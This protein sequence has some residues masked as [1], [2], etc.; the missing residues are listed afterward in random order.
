M[1]TKLNYT[2]FDPAHLGD[3]IDLEQSNTV[4]SVGT[5]NTLNQYTRALYGKAKGSWRSELIV[6]GSA[7]IAGA[8]SVGLV[9]ASADTAS[10]VGGDANGYGYLLAEGE[11]HNDG[12]D[13]AT[14]SGLPVIAKGDV[15]GVELDAT[16]PDNPVATWKLNGQPIAS[17][18]IAPGTWYV[19]VSLAVPSGTDTLMAFINGGQRAFDYPALARGWYDIPPQLPTARVASADYIASANDALAHAVYDGCIEA[20]SFVI[21]RGIQFWVDGKAATRNQTGSLT[22]LNPDGIYDWLVDEDV[23]GLEVYLNITSQGEDFDSAAGVGRFTIKDAVAIDDGKIKLSLEDALA[24]LDVPLQR[25]L[26]HPDAEESAANKPW[27]III[28]AAR[29]VSPVLLDS[30][31]LIYALSD[32]AV[33]GLGYIRDKGDPWDPNAVPPD[34]TISADRRRMT[35]DSGSAP[36]GKVTADLSSV[37]GGT[38][39]TSA[40]DVFDQ[41]GHPFIA[42]SDNKPAGFEIIEFAGGDPSSVDMYQTN[43]V[44][45]KAGLLDAGLVY[46]TYIPGRYY[47]YRIKFSFLSHGD[48]DVF[49]TLYL[50]AKGD[51]GSGVKWHYVT[52][53]FAVRD[54][55]PAFGGYGGVGVSTIE[56]VF[57]GPGPGTFGGPNPPPVGLIYHGD[58][59]DV[60]VYE[61]EI[62]LIP[63]TYTPA[64]IDPAKLTDFVRG[65]LQDRY[66]LSP[67]EWSAADTQAIDDASGYTGIGWNANDTVTVRQALDEVLPSYGAACYQDKNKVLRFPRFV[68]PEDAA[69]SDTL[70]IYADDFLSEL[71]KELDRAP[72][73]TTRAGFKKNWTILNASDF[74][75]DFLDVPRDVR[76]ALSDTHQ[77]F[78]ASAVQLPQAYKH[79]V[80]AAPLDGCLDSKDNTQTE[81]VRANSI[82]SILRHFYK[83]DLPNSITI[84]PG[85]IVRVFYNKH[86]LQEGKY[87]Q[88]RKIDERPLDETMTVT[89]WG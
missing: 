23:Q 54:N 26:I 18:V 61:A 63:E 41:L 4:I 84:E 79:A 55:D 88:V 5:T 67:T 89:F 38:E 40:D 57:Q 21:S 27:P 53:G 17:L 44:R 45:M 30:A 86:G 47:R 81:I 78:V 66:G 11:L 35:V 69:D 49:S 28:G 34:Y 48:G 59:G 8:T 75:T 60:I 32:Q 19:A 31:N 71:T 20:D 58:G 24:E 25:M 77:G 3:G 7:S 72:G 22:L 64:A 33:I 36:Q 74:V 1:T 87:L 12:A 6:W 73:L 16:D 39:P 68:A 65:I 2:T 46:G 80:S 43:K 70:D 14:T 62:F 10:Y 76:R 85:D 52:G 56:G 50:G 82:M 83:G 13:V 51:Y 9:N 29:S 37:G 15:I 42:D